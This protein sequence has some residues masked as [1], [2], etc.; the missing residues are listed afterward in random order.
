MFE[1]FAGGNVSRN[2]AGGILLACCALIFA[3]AKCRDNR[4]D[5]GPRSNVDAGP[6]AST[7][8]AINGNKLGRY[9][10]RPQTEDAGSPGADA[11]CEN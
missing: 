3:L 7:G 10:A 9:L 5:G 1:W 6:G 8:G 4:Q 2:R 11:D